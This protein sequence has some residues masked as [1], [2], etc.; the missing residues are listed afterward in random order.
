MEN[1]SAVKKE[2]KIAYLI[3]CIL[4]NLKPKYKLII[5]KDINGISL[6]LKK[7]WEKIWGCT[8][9]K[10]QPNNPQRLLLVLFLIILKKKLMKRKIKKNLQNV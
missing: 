10:E 5:I 6:E 9:I 8:I 1:A 2:N 3:F 7:E 4:I